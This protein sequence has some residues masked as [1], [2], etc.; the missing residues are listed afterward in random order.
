MITQMVL[1]RH[2]LPIFRYCSQ[3]VP[4]LVIGFIMQVVVRFYG[5]L[6]GESVSTLVA[7]VLLG[8]LV[9][10]IGCVVYF[11]LSKDEIGSL[12]FNEIK[13]IKRRRMR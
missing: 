11:I 5:K 12:I 13:S 3:T 6:R 2:K 7:Q 9:Y 1:I 4:Y 8:A 10:S